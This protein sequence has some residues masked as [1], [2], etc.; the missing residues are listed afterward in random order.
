MALWEP[1]INV[2]DE[3]GAKRALKSHILAVQSDALRWANDGE[4]LPAFKKENV[5][6]S[7]RMVTAFPALTF[8]NS[9]H[10]WRTEGDILAVRFAV[11]VEVALQNGR[12]DWLT[13]NAPKYSMALESIFANLPETTF[14][15]DSKI[16]TT[17]TIEAME[18][19]FDVQGRTKKNQFI[20]VFQIEAQWRIDA[21]LYTE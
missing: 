4:A 7:P 19:S 21:A 16:E 11:A 3:R 10:D 14:N 1:K 18:T 8:L 15:R 20:E 12:Q 6:L 13:E 5:H 2:F 9:S 17:V